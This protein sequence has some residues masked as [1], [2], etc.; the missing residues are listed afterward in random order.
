MVGLVSRV[1]YGVQFV[2]GF[3]VRGFLWESE[4]LDDFCPSNCT[5]NHL[6]RLMNNV[7]RVPSDAPGGPVNVPGN[8]MDVPGI[9]VCVLLERGLSGH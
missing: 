2:Q 8:F 3:E 7:R 9:L 5:H 1:M 4:Y 6:F